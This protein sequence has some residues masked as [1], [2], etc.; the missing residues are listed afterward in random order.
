MTLH[1]PD[2]AEFNP[3]NKEHRIAFDKFLQ[4]YSWADA[5]IRFKEDSAYTNIVSQLKDKTLKWYMSQEL[6]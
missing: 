2:R 3:A 4:R 6:N 5:G 1:I